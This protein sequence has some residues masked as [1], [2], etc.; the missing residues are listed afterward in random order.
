MGFLKDVDISP[1]RQTAVRPAPVGLRLGSLRELGSGS[2]A[3]RRVLF[4]FGCCAA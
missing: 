3:V 1:G 4:L 2:Q